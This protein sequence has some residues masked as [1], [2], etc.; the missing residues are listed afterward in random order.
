MPDKN[1]NISEAALQLTEVVSLIN[2]VNDFSIALD[3]IL[4]TCVEYLKIPHVGVARF[5]EDEEKFQIVKSRNFDQNLKDCFRFNLFTPINNFVIRKERTSAFKNLGSSIQIGNE[6]FE[7]ES[8]FK[9][10]YLLPFRFHEQI[11]GF[12]IIHIYQSED[13]LSESTLTLLES[14]VNLVAPIFHVFGPLK[15]HKRGGENIISKIIKDRINEARLG[16][17]PVSFA[18]FR[19]QLWQEMISSVALQDTVQTYQQV[20]EKQLGQLGDVIWLTLDTA[21]FIFPNADLFT[22]ESLC[23]TLKEEVESN[24]N[25]QPG[26]VQINV[27]YVSISYPQSG[28]E[29]YDIINQLWLR[30][31]DEL[32]ADLATNH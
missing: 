18:I 16:L 30:L 7:L 11:N 14:F 24:F 17:F 15:T 1:L 22:I 26:Q 8:A 4:D 13:D 2:Q 27:K 23:N 28:K 21:F 25:K 20:F 19:I 32:Q 3:M 5:K 12:L 29:G 10:L 9:T 31:F 6:R